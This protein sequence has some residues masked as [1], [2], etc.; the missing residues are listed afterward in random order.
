[1]TISKRAYFWLLVVAILLLCL[2]PATAKAASIT[3]DPGMGEK[4]IAAAISSAKNNDQIVFAKGTYKG[5]FAVANSWAYLTFEDGVVLKDASFI[6]GDG[7]KDCTVI[8]FAQKPVTLYKI[9]VKDK[10]HL[11]VQGKFVN[12]GKITSSSSLMVEG[13]TLTNKSKAT[14]AISGNLAI[15][16]GELVNEK[17]GKITAV[18]GY[19]NIEKAGILTN[20]GAFTLGNGT[21]KGSMYVGNRNKIDNSGT[22]TLNGAML[23][24]V[25]GEIANSGTLEIKAGALNCQYKTVLNNTGKIKNNYEFNNRGEIKGKGSITQGTKGWLLDYSSALSANT[26]KGGAYYRGFVIEI[27][28]ASGRTIA[29]PSMK[30]NGYKYPMR[31]WEPETVGKDSL[32]T[33][34]KGDVLTV[35]ASGYQD[36]TIEVT[37]DII[38]G[39]SNKIIVTMEK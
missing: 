18:K 23:E 22:L 39:K 32:S 3:I 38:S 25:T 16:N 17:G 27:K 28:D 11:A 7:K 37:A 14:I 24:N 9:E 2:I 5:T 34:K 19:F 12:A 31:S 8:I 26:P 36:A 4:E 15:V 6:F 10:T 33:L 21:E 13:G 20:K 29:K 35:S 30:C 1:M